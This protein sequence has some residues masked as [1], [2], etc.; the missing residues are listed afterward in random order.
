MR[1]QSVLYRQAVAPLYI[2]EAQTQR[3]VGFTC[4]GLRLEDVSAL[5]F[6]VEAS[7]VTPG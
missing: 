6:V 2:L 7:G 1:L 3:A 5:P 4:L